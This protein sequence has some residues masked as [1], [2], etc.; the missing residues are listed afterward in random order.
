[1]P[2]SPV[3]AIAPDV[4]AYFQ[5]Q[6][7]GA[8]KA[9]RVDATEAASSYLV[10]LLAGFAAPT[11]AIR[12]TFDVPLTFQ[13]R[14]AMEGSGQQRFEALRSL[15]DRVLYALGFFGVAIETRVD[16]SYV[17]GVGSSAYENA[18]AMLRLR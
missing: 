6:L 2:S 16:R 4:S 8:I 15:G 10:A 18:A 14:D 12:S 9:R 5:E 11:E 13:L 1:M 3:L 7:D 17:V